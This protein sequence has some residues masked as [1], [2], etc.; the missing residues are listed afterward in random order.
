MVSQSFVARRQNFSSEEKFRT[1]YSNPDEI[2]RMPT[3]L[4][5][6]WNS[7]RAK[8]CRAS[9]TINDRLL[10]R[11]I[12]WQNHDD[13][14]AFAPRA[15]NRQATAHLF[16]AFPHSGQA[17]PVMS[18]VRFETSSIVL[19]FQTDFLGTKAQARFKAGGMS[20]LKSIR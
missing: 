17:K 19:K 2:W 20:V 9:A 18:A 12:A 15:R 7:D 13:S 3:D 4:R 6:P 11:T 10:L 14:C 8:G 5:N 1:I 16:D